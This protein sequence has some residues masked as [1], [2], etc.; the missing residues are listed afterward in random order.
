MLSSS[1]IAF[2]LSASLGDK[3]LFS[4]ANILQIADVVRQVVLVLFL[5]CFE[6]IVRLFLP[7]ETSEVSAILYL[8]PKR[9]SL[10]PRSPRLTVQKSSKFAAHL[11]PFFTYRK[12]LPNMVGS[13]WL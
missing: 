4:T 3:G 5:L 7:R 6:S 1:R 9:L 2:F 8:R 12:I 13:I 10:V 11:T